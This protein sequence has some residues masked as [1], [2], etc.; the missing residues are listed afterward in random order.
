MDLLES[1]RNTD[2]NSD[3]FSTLVFVRWRSIRYCTVVVNRKTL[4]T[5]EDRIRKTGR[6]RLRL[7]SYSEDWK[8]SITIENRIQFRTGTIEDNVDSS[9]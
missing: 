8:I 9:R 3:E 2:S 1:I 6:F 7:K 5:I 4:I